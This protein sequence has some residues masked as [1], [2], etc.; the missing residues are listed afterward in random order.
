MNGAKKFIATIREY[1]AR[2]SFVK[3][4]RDARRGGAKKF[5]ATIRLFQK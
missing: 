4:P 5:I 3:L 1:L 2:R